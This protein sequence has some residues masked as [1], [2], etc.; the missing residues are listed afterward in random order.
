MFTGIIEITGSVVECREENGGRTLAVRAPFKAVLGESIAVDGACVTVS[1]LFKE[2]LRCW[3]SPET[4]SRT[5]LGTLGPGSTVHLERALPADGRLGGHV[6][7]GHVDGVA[8]VV[9]RQERGDSIVLSLRA[10]EGM[11]RYLV[12]RGSVALAGV[13]LTVNEVEGDAFRVTLIPFTQRLTFLGN[14]RSGGTVN[15]ESDV[16]MKQV[17]RTVER[18]LGTSGEGG[19]TE[20]LLRRTGFMDEE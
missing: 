1:G 19:V 9:E 12:P 6:V 3:L 2:G 11:G 5:T 20:E 7:T 13:S 8:G 16:I 10:P 14:L 17:V 4:L 15:F 18:I